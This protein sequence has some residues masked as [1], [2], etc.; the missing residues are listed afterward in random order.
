MWDQNTTGFIKWNVDSVPTIYEDALVMLSQGQEQ[1]K[2]VGY[3]FNSFL[4][5]DSALQAPVGGTR[6]IIYKG[7]ALKTVAIANNLGGYSN[8]TIGTLWLVVE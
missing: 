4:T 5:T 2:I 6:N 1:Y 8:A 7:Q 3:V